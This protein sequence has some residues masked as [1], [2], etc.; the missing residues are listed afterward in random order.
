MTFTIAIRRPAAVHAV[1]ISVALGGLLVPLNSS[2]IVV[3]LPI[4]MKELRVSVDAAGWLVTAY[5][6]ATATLQLIAGKLGDQFGRRRFVL[7]GLI[8]FGMASLFAA[9][10]P[11]FPFLLFFR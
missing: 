3:V 6:V 9:L 10:S 7:G 1:L 2:M 5:L 11:S 4:V 8:W